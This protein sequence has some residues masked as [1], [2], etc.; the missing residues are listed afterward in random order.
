MKEKKNMVSVPNC[1]FQVYL[2]IYSMKKKN[3]YLILG[4]IVAIFFLFIC[5]NAEIKKEYRITFY[6]FLAL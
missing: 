1:T 2:V 5:F 4:I 3:S 6:L